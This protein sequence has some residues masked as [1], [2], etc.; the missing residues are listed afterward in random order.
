LGDIT[1]VRSA[2]QLARAAP[3]RGGGGGGAERVLVL[4]PAWRESEQ[5]WMQAYARFVAGGKRATVLVW[6]D[7]C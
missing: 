1:T 7:S 5:G 6:G 4:D 2:H 3:S